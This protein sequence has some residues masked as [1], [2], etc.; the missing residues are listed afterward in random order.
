L[1]TDQLRLRLFAIATPIIVQSLVHYL[2]IQ[3]DMAMLGN[4]NT[5]YLSAVGNVLYPYSIM[6]FFL[7]ALSA[8]A[9]VMISHSIGARSLKSAK[10]FAEVSFFYNVAIA[11][12][13][14]LV[15]AFMAHILMAWMGTS[16]QIN[17]YAT[18]YME[19]LSYSVLFLGVELSII[20]ILQ[21]IGRT[22]TI[23]YAAIL[24]TVANI[25]FDW[26]LINGRLGF[27]E[28]GISGAAI[29]TSI[30]NLMGM[31]LLITAFITTK[32]LPFKPS[33]RGILNPRWAIQKQSMAVGIPYGLEAIFWSFG[34][35]VIIRMVNE[36]NDYAAGLYILLTRI[37]AFTFFFYQGIA[38][39]TM[40]LIGQVMGAG[41]RALAF[42]IG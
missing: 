42:K 12:P 19:G 26:V 9:T 10:R 15:L 32:K 7:T 20:A 38:R 36:L 2:Q 8:G 17:L 33:L 16:D 6:I 18:A 22:R 25:F 29:A 23:M 14:F 34:Q 1:K 13:F 30:S 35:I 4:Y 40:T 28:M 41:D 31:V 37:Q 27:P 21:G 39:A 3:V 5:Q 24:R 11:I